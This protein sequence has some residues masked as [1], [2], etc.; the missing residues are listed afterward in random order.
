MSTP[1]SP[2]YDPLKVSQILD[3]PV[4]ITSDTLNR[5]YEGTLTAVDHK[6]SI[7]LSSAMETR[8]YEEE[9][10]WIKV[11]REVGQVN[12]EAKFITGIF[13]KKE[14]YDKRQEEVG[15]KESENL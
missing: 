10:E 14:M 1:E 9:G 15:G 13:A 2:P 6:D 11:K 3:L 12:I 5:I 7:L 4:V 8:V